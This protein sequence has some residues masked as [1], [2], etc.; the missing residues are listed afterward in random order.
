MAHRCLKSAKLLVLRQLVFFLGQSYLIYCLRSKK[1]LLVQSSVGEY[2]T[3]FFES[4]NTRKS[5]SLTVVIK[6]KIE[7]KIFCYGN[8]DDCS[9]SKTAVF[10]GKSVINRCASC[11]FP[12]RYNLKFSADMPNKFGFLRKETNSGNFLLTM[13]ISVRLDSTSSIE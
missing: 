1:T 4:A 2:N 7:L 5:R 11:R 9:H 6:K 8:N 13:P 3:L 10:Q 12:T